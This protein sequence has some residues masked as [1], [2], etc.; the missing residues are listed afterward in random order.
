MSCLGHGP[1]TVKRFDCL[2]GMSLMRQGLADSPMPS[3]NLLVR[4]LVYC[5][6]P[7]CARAVYIRQ[8][9]IIKHS[10]CDIPL[11]FGL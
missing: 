2:Q 7:C 9:F 10:M 3:T 8:T 5:L 6:C 1:M 4:E 11:D